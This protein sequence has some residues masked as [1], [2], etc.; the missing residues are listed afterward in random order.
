[1]KKK[2]I[3]ILLLFIVSLT[4]FYKALPLDKMLYGTDW[5]SG[6][7]FQH[8]YVAD[9]IKSHK[10]LPLWD[11]FLLGGIPTVGALWGDFFYPSFILRFLLPVYIVWTWKF[12]LHIFIAGL[13]T[14]LFLRYRKIKDE[15]AAIGGIS[16]MLAAM[17]VSPVYGGH[18]GRVMTMALFPVYLYFFYRGVK[19]KRY[20]FYGLSGFVMGLALLTV[21]IQIVYYGIV[22]VAFYSIYLSWREWRWT[23][24]DAIPLYIAGIVSFIISVFSTIIGFLMFV[25]FYLGYVLYR[26]KGDIKNL[27]TLYGFIFAMLIMGM[28]IAIQFIPS[29]QY[30]PYAKRGEDRGYEYAIS[31]SMPASETV[32]LVNPEI[33]GLL[34]NYKGTNPFKLHSRYMGLLPILLVLSLLFSRKFDG[35]R[36]FWLFSLIIAYLIAIGGQTPFF[37]IPYYFLPKFKLFRAP[38]LI[39]FIINFSFIVLAVDYIKDIKKKELIYSMSAIGVVILLSLIVVHKPIESANIF[40]WYS[41]KALFLIGAFTFLLLNYKK[42]ENNLYIYILMGLVIFDLFTVDWRYIKTEEKPS[43][44]FPRD[45]I[46]QYLSEEYKKMPFRVF[47]ALNAY[48]MSD[49]FFTY[50]NIAIAGGNHPNPM[51]RYQTYLGLS[52][53]MFNPS[54]LIKNHG[55]MAHLGVRYIIG[56]NIELL[57]NDKRYENLI[58]QW[59]EIFPLDSFSLIRTQGPIGLFEFDYA[60][61]YIYVSEQTLFGDSIFALNGVSNINTDI[62]ELKN[63]RTM[64][65][66]GTVSIVSSNANEFICK[67]QMEREGYLIRNENYYKNWH[68]QIDGKEVSLLRANY[69]AQAVFVPEGDHIVKFYYKEPF[70]LYGIILW[71]LGIAILVAVYV[72]E[73]RRI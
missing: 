68:V 33:H 56:P 26:K 21:H 22:F 40:R 58:N 31:W 51:A 9:Y 52:G 35:E 46:T 45:N 54:T 72:V 70:I 37:K 55:K 12:I 7:I 67:V 44:F 27:H 62:I 6:T 71:L 29:F 63:S 66:K 43:S 38:D 39:F 23:N 14:F 4:L 1:M 34:Q 36:K 57:K 18:D 13:F 11:S 24:K 60:K 16:Y 32:D 47:S 65:G 5:L 42:G 69:I 20:F 10:I 19:E 50:Y 41:I 8:V 15:L 59:G 48:Q 49:D 3:Y 61:P 73:K 2:H 25:L 17:V 53:V 30:L 28:T 64:N